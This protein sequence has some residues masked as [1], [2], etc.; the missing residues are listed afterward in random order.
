MHLFALR[1]VVAGRDY[2]FL[3]FVVN[4]KPLD[5]V[6]SDLTVTWFDYSSIEND[7]DEVV[8]GCVKLIDI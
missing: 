3:G 2:H 4:K 1:L 5:I 8:I 7:F 6:S